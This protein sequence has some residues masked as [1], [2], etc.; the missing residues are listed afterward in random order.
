MKNMLNI[1][2]HDNTRD[3][4]QNEEYQEC[5]T[6]LRTIANDIFNNVG[7][8]YC[9]QIYENMFAVE[10]DKNNIEY[11]RWYR[12]EVMYCDKLVGAYDAP[13]FIKLPHD[14]H[15]IVEILAEKSSPLLHEMGIVKNKM[16][17]CVPKANCAVLINFGSSH[18]TQR[19]NVDFY[20]L[21]NY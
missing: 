7:R 9:A 10:L 21:K 11:T 4:I 12:I 2:I 3:Y 15:C 6:K 20:C 5:I 16:M 18:L 8:N 13:F 19:N 14:H 1:D 17:H